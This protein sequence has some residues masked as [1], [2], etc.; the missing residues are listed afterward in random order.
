MRKKVFKLRGHHIDTIYWIRY[1]L[2][3]DYAEFRK[4]MDRYGYVKRGNG[5]FVEGVYRA[6]INLLKD[7]TNRV[8]ITDSFDDICNLGC[9]S[10]NIYCSQKWVDRNPPKAYGLDVGVT[11]TIEEIIN[12]MEKYHLRFKPSQK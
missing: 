5:T 4:S 2:G 6:V 1:R 7:P 9:P 3:G 10:K 8:R 12:A 11:Y